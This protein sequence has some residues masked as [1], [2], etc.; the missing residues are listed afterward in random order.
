MTE[1]AAPDAVELAQP[2]LPVP[3]LLAVRNVRWVSVEQ[4]ITDAFNWLAA[5][6]S[7]RLRQA[8]HE[9]ATG[10]TS[11]HTD[12][13]IWD[14]QSRPGVHMAADA[15]AYLPSGQA[16]VIYEVK[17]GGSRSTPYGAHRVNLAL[18]RKTGH[19]S[20][21]PDAVAWHAALEARAQALHPH[22]SGWHVKAEC[23]QLGC[24]DN[25]EHNY[26]RGSQRRRAGVAQPAAYLYSNWLP[27][28][29]HTSQ[30]TLLVVLGGHGKSVAAYYDSDDPAFTTTP[31]RFILTTHRDFLDRLATKCGGLVLNSS[32][33]YLMCEVA[34]RMWL[35]L[36]WDEASD[37]TPA[38]HSLVA[39]EA[40]DAA[41]PYEYPKR[42]QCLCK[43]CRGRRSAH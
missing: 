13:R 10:R 22:A 34:T 32:D 19:N 6:A 24:Q 23:K 5:A 42:R 36:T 21:D 11:R 2:A 9:A 1:S 17:R 25:W 37:L 28:S 30:D 33:H 41:L 29:L 16:A 39:P 4:R 18:V 3:A 14:P 20:G 38:A 40:L 35:D 7:P 31:N 27:P 43:P 12:I 15:V 26:E 8:V